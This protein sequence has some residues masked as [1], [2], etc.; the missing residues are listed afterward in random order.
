MEIRVLGDTAAYQHGCKISRNVDDV[1]VTD[2]NVT[3]HFRSDEE[4]QAALLNVWRRRSL[5]LVSFRSR[6]GEL[7]GCIYGRHERKGT[8]SE[9]LTAII[10]RFRWNAPRIGFNP[11]LVKRNPPSI[12]E[13]TAFTAHSCSCWRQPA[14]FFGG[15]RWPAELL[16]YQ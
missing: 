4:A 13:P 10:T 1:E 2:R 6:E 8:V 9:G 14:G 15:W 7:G 12:E 16:Y 11:I 5:P 3:F